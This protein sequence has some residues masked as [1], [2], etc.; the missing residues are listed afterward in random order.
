LATAVVTDY[1]SHHAALGT[2]NNTP[3]GFRIIS[4]D[5]RVEDES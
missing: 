2:Y 1:R 4:D 3:A 5:D